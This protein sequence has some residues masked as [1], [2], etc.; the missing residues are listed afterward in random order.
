MVQRFTWDHAWKFPSRPPLTS[1]CGA[2]GVLE[3]P[4]E[5]IPGVS[6]G[7]PVHIPRLNIGLTT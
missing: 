7:I 3:N 5:Q 1:K 2:W 4:P 6:G